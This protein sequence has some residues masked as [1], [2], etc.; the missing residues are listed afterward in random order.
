MVLWS[1][2]ND[3]KDLSTDYCSTMRKQLQFIYLNKKNIIW[4]RGNKDRF[5]GYRTSQLLNT[6]RNGFGENALASSPER[7]GVRSFLSQ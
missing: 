2:G 1:L 4:A 6:A 3:K 7:Y 5:M